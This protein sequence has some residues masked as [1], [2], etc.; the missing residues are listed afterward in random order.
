MCA[1]FLD[2]RNELVFLGDYTLKTMSNQPEVVNNSEQ[3]F[4]VV[5][6]KRYSSQCESTDWGRLDKV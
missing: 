2:S 3:P 4:Q 1:L 5:T 6:Q